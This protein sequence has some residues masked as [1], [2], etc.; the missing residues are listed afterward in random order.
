VYNNFEVLK[1][2]A[3]EPE[4]MQTLYSQVYLLKWLQDFRINLPSQQTRENREGWPL[5]TLETETNGNTKSTNERVPSLV[6][7]LG[8][9]Y[10]RYKSLLS[11]L[12]FSSWPSTKYFFPCHTLFQLNLSASPSKLGRQSYVSLQQT[13]LHSK[14]SLPPSTI[15]TLSSRTGIQR[16]GV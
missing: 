6:G 12:G 5:L 10:N 2:N 3:C 7:S 13:V 9:S 15:K 4:N 8:S 11:C 14:L 16:H 1:L